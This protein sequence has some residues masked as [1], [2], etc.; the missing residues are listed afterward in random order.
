VTQ[1]PAR[2]RASRTVRGLLAAGLAV[3]V[4]AF[5]HVA[6]GGA[7]PAPVT[8]A[9]T[10]A[11]AAPLAIAFAGRRL[12]AVRVAA[13]VVLSQVLF[14]VLFTL[15]P[16]DAGG[17]VHAGHAHGDALVLPALDSVVPPMW[18]AHALAALVTTAALLAGSRALGAVEKVGDLVLRRLLTALAP[19]QPVVVRKAPLPETAAPVLDDRLVVALALRHRGPPALAV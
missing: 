3:H 16:A 8:V 7:A 14:H 9:L 5:F 4:A 18:Q 15:S 6:G 10:M 1:Q 11:F 12:G 17:P 19:T 2:T 13:T